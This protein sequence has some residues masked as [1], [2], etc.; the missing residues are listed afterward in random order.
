MKK[1]KSNKVS[2]GRGSN[3][4]FSTWDKKF[5]IKT[6]NI[7][8]RKILVEKMIVDY[9]CLMKESRS[10]LSRVYGV[11][12]IELKDKGTINVIIQ[13]NMNDLPILTKLLTFDIKGSTVDRQSISK[14]DMNLNKQD[15][16]NKYKNKVLEDID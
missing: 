3:C 16:L 6:V 15:L 7:T 9:H 8:E 10:L 4:I 11:F 12:K 2:G 1:L 14:D 13:R 5:I